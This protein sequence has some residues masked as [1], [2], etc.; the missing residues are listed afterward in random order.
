[1][2]TLHKHK[3]INDEVAFGFMTKRMGLRESLKPPYKVEVEEGEY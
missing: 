1:M 3:M 2:D